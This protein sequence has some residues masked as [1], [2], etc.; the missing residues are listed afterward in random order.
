MRLLFKVFYLAITLLT[1]LLIV[2]PFLAISNAP[3]VTPSQ[4]IN[5]ESLIKLKKQLSKNNPFKHRVQQ[6]RTVK[7]SEATL[8]QA[9]QL[10][11]EQKKIPIPTQVDLLDNKAQIKNS[12][13]IPDT[14]FYLN[15]QTDLQV[16]NDKLQLEQLRIG[17]L[18]LPSVI[19]ELFYPMIVSSIDR[20]FPE[21]GAAWDNI[22]K[23][24][25]QSKHVIVTYYW[26]QALKEKLRAATQD[27]IMPEKDKA[28]VRVYYLK[29]AEFRPLQRIF[30]THLHQILQPL[31][32]FVKERTEISDDPVAENRAAIIA[33]ALAISRIKPHMIFGENLPRAVFY[34]PVLLKRN[35]LA[36]H[37]ILS[38]A[39]SVV[40]NS[41]LS[42][43]IGL[44]KEIDDSRGG[45]GFSFPDLLADKA[46]TNLGTLAT[47]N[48]ESANR[49][50]AIL[51]NK[52][53]REVDIMPSYTNLPE[54]ISELQ[55]KRRYIDISHPNY[56]IVEN[57]INRRISDTLLFKKQA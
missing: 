54:A 45:S 30:P 14:T 56:Q 29:L 50:Q 26:N 5:H 4:K 51:A 11:L 13:N 32:A 7:F 16:K 43:A 42:E 35:D 37:Y 33:L 57:E 17:N 21:L 46:G 23:I 22:R 1:L 31:F 41:A 39:L 47:K 20:H 36:L 6:L 12:Y 55:F 40:T 10:G 18:V 24:Q 52:N 8:N 9:I 49:I 25:I 44:A 28:I 38:T 53:L 27:L 34:R 19:V 15:F 48:K 2:T 3:D